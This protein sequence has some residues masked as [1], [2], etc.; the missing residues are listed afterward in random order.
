MSQVLNAAST[1]ERFRAANMTYDGASA[2]TTIAAQVPPNDAN[3]YYNIALSNLSRTTYTIT[4][5]PTGSMTGQDGPLTIDQAG[6]RT[7]EDEDG[8]SHNCWPQSGN[9]C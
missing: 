5:T 6:R 3:P 4:A 2:G 7:W 9:S 8:V 1:M